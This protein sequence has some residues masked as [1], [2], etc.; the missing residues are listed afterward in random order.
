MLPSEDPI[1]FELFV[2][3]LYD[4]VY[5][6]ED[7]LPATQT[8]G[9]NIDVQAWILGDKLRSTNFKNYVMGRLHLQY[10]AESEPTLIVPTD[11]H[12][13]LIYSAPASQLCTFF[14]HLVVKWFQD[15]TRAKGTTAQWDEVLQKHDCLRVGLIN[16][17][18]SGAYREKGLYSAKFFM[19][20]E[21]AAPTQKPRDMGSNMVTP[22][23]RN[24]EGEQV[25]KEPRGA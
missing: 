8:L 2:E 4:G 13:A 6:L 24:A 3:W 20:V 11:L 22:A 15:P 19:E 12:Y 14:V 16:G 17:L 7:P 21:N 1:I 25:K 9:I 23:K 10:A 18:R 5:T